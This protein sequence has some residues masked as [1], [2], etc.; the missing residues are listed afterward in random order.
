[1][2]I[3]HV[4]QNGVG[5]PKNKNCKFIITLHDV[6]P[7]RMPETVSDR[8]LK[9][10]SEEIPKIVSSADG[11]ITVSD[12]S[13]KDI[14]KSFNYPEDKIFVTH[15]ASEDIYMPL[16]KEFCRNILKM[17]YNINKNFILYVGGFS[18]R[19]IY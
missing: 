11:I 19:K 18:P 9:I 15:L 8:Y 3:Y 2:D 7:Y 10:F 6:I 17:K 4:P 1:M 12:F 16:N 14:M 13:K 5:L